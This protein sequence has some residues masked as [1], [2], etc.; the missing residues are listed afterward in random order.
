MHSCVRGG[1]AVYLRDDDFGAFMCEVDSGAFTCGMMILV[2]SCVSG[3]I[4][5]HR[6][7]VHLPEA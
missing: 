1:I 7:F 2:H 5:V 6:M 4:W 3:R